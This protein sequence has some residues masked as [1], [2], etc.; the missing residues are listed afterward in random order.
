MLRAVRADG[1]ALGA[2]PAPVRTVAALVEAE[3]IRQR[4]LPSPQRRGEEMH[5]IRHDHITGNA[6]ACGSIPRSSDLTVRIGARQY[7]LV[8][9]RTHCYEYN[10]GLTEPFARW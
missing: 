7:L 3:A 8:V 9:V 4:L 5:M 1:V 10:R 6:P 2:S